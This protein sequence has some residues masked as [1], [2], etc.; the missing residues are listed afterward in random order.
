MLSK[1]REGGILNHVEEL[2]IKGFQSAS[3][4]GSPLILVSCPPACHEI[5]DLSEKLSILVQNQRIRMIHF[6]LPMVNHYNWMSI[7]NLTLILKRNFELTLV[8][9]SNGYFCC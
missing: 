1:I 2:V 6:D 4:N 3:K 7:L 9:Q 8:S 5:A